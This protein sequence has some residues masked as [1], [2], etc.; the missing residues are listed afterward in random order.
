MKN[1]VMIDNVNENEYYENT[2]SSSMIMLHETIVDVNKDNSQVNVVFQ[3][4]VTS[5]EICETNFCNPVRRHS[6]HLRQFMK[7]S[8]Q[9]H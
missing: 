6:I 1:V 9:Y 4:T 2:M 3:Q 5:G 8:G 7:T